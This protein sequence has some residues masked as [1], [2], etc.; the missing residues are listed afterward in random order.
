MKPLFYEL[1]LDLGTNFSSAYNSILISRTDRTF[2][3]VGTNQK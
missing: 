1:V 2:C 3:D